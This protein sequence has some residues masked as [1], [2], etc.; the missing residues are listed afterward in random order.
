MELSQGS[1]KVMNIPNM[2]GNLM[3]IENYKQSTTRYEVK[4]LYKILFTLVK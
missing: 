2:I 3:T 4:Q 1:P